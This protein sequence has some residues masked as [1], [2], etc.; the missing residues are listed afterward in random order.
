M[1]T[2]E[3]ILFPDLGVDQI[4][5]SSVPYEAEETRRISSPVEEEMEESVTI[6]EVP[7]GVC[8]YKTGEYKPVADQLLPQELYPLVQDC[9]VDCISNILLIYKEKVL[10]GKWHSYPDIRWWFSCG[11]PIRPGL[12]PR[13]NCQQL[14]E[15]ML[16]VS[17]HNINR[18]EYV[19][20]YSYLWC[21]RN[22]HVGDQ[23]FHNFSVVWAINL[24]QD[25]LPQSFSK[26]DF[27]EMKWM[28][29]ADLVPGDFHPALCR[30]IK[31]YQSVNAITTLIHNVIS[32][33]ETEVSVIGEKFMTWSLNKTKR[34]VIENKAKSDVEK[35]SSKME[36]KPENIVHSREAEVETKMNVGNAQDVKMS[37]AGECAEHNNS[38]DEISNARL[39]R[40]EDSSEV[41]S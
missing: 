6:T 40:H 11:G 28:T 15:R 2:I 12:T 14:C 30:A 5:A 4:V 35:V 19:G 24:Q 1:G 26:E 23:N 39:K 18:F 25:E 32:S 29:L 33:K 37:E 34:W 8:H 41:E 16:E 10:L 20:S 9:V 3:S 17:I 36:D 22:K 7:I 13:E 21:L 27:V 31:D 38:I